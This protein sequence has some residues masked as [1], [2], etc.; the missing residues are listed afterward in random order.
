MIWEGDP[1]ELRS[2]T[3]ICAFAGWN[4]AAGAASTALETIAASFES[5]VVARLD[6]EEFYDFQV[7][8]PTIRLEDGRDQATWTGRTTPSSRR[9]SRGPRGTS[10]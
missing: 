5:E 6:P 3:L 1:P 4:D 10:S 9:R 7:N 2:P 8:R